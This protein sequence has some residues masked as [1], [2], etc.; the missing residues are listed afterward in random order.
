MNRIRGAWNRNFHLHNNWNTVV[1]IWRSSIGDRKRTTKKLCD[2]H[3]AERPGE[4]SGAIR[5][6]ALILLGND[7]CNPLGLFRKF[8]GALRA[9]FWLCG[10]FWA[11]DRNS[12]EWER[13]RDVGGRAPITLAPPTHAHSTRHSPSHWSRGQSPHHNQDHD[14]IITMK[15]KSPLL[16]AQK[17]GGRKRYFWQTAVLP[18]WHPP[19]SSFLSSSGAWGAKPLVFVCRMQIII[20]AF[21]V[22]ATC[23]R[24]GQKHRFPKTPFSQPSQK[25]T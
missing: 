14:P 11:P 20:F 4:L 13:E 23:F 5:L 8:F 15:P 21:F 3:F 18:E 6:K 16:E 12:R 19:F 7:P 17:I 22:K 2:K 9:I 25:G 1:A 10:S 24:Q